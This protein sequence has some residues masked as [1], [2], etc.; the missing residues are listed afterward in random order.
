MLHLIALAA[1]VPALLIALWPRHPSYIAERNGSWIAEQRKVFA[2]VL[3]EWR[4]V[5]GGTY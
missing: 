3:T 2:G 4:G 5:P 1:A